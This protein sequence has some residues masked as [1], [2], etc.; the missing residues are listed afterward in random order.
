MK[1]LIVTIAAVVMA[2]GVHAAAMDW[3]TGVFNGPDGNSSNTGSKYSGVYQATIYVFSDAACETQL[4]TASSDAVTKKGMINSTV[5]VAEPAS[6]V[7]STYYTKLVI[8][9]IA[10]GKALESTVGSFTWTGGDLTA[11]SL[12]FYGADAG[13]F[14]TGGAPSASTAGWQT[15]P[16]PTSA[17]LLLIGAGLVGLRRKRV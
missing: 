7:T 1:K 12:T 11:P 17:L 13:G 15:V 3:S 4:G 5:D 9:E 8:T 14:A 16:E 2:L 10:T 6:G